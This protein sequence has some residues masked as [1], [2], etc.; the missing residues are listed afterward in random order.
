MSVLTKRLRELSLA[1]PEGVCRQAAETIERLEQEVTDLKEMG[2]GKCRFPDGVVIKPDGKNI[3][4]PCHYEPI[5]KYA[6]V[7]IEVRKCRNCG[8]VDIGWWKQ[9]D[10]VELEV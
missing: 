1:D 4:D 3:L 9:D 2:F 6:N 5:E 10:T 7:T 8:T